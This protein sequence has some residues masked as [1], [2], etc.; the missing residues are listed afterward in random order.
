ML[1]QLAIDSLELAD[2]ERLVSTLRD[3]VDVVEI[4]TPIIIR[5]GVG[6]VQ[7]L[8]APSPTCR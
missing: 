1:L 6:A 8:R 5:S 2:A 4:G 3:L 7:R